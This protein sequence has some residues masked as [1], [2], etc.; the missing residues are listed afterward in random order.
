MIRAEYKDKE[1]IVEILTNS[2]QDNK[3]VNYILKQ[4]QKRVQRIR[5]LMA[6]SFD[7][8]YMFGDVFLSEDKSGCALLVFPEKKKMTVKSIFLNVK[9]MFT[10][11]GLS[12]VKKT[13]HSEWKIRKLQPRGTNILSLVYWSRSTTTK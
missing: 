7:F 8:C 2:F 10:C 4:D 13:L 5:N 11:S 1:R 9:L 3:S 12:N 6:Y